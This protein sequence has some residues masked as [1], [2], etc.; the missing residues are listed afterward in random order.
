VTENGFHPGLPVVIVLAAGRGERFRAAGRG[1]DKLD[2]L[3]S[4]QRLRDH[5][6]ASVR[7]S[8][9]AWHVVERDH[10]AHLAAPGMGSSIASGVAATRTASG[11]LILPADLP[12]V[13][14]DTL[15]EVAAALQEH[16]VVVPF[17]Q[18]R[19]GH[20]VGF[21]LACRTALLSLQG[22][23]GARTIVASWP[24]FY[25]LALNDPGCVLDVDT[26][27][28]LLAVQALLNAPSAT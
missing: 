22:D 6:L 4:G 23:A 11:W 26:V 19:R 24:S 14:P 7:A 16:D 13:R 3:L 27:D 5:V 9:L 10:T 1:I 20:P 17:Y 12:L 18:G 8:G 21:S 28:D 2:A 25:R 15:L